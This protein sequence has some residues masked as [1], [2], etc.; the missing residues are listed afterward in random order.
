MLLN[1][2][3]YATGTSGKETEIKNMLFKEMKKCIKNVKEDK[4]AT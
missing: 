2:L 1:R 4:L 3:I